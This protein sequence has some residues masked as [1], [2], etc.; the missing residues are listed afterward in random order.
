MDDD[1]GD[2]DEEEIEDCGGGGNVGDVVELFME[3]SLVEPE[4]KIGQDIDDIDDG[5]DGDDDDDG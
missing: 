3:N 2:G 4:E 5:N 1:W